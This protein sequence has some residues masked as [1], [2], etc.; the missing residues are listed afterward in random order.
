MRRLLIIGVTLVMALNGVAAP[1][2]K[3]ENNEKPVKHYID[4]FGGAGVSSFGYS[5]E[6]GKNMIGVSF[7]VGAGYTWF[8]KPYMGLQTGLSL[9]RIASTASLT[10]PM[11]WDKWQDGSP[12]TDYMGEKYIHRTTFDGW[13]E[14]QQA[15]LIQ[16]PI[17]LRFRYF[18][19][20]DQKAG[21]HA[22]VGVNLSIPVISSYAHTAGNVT[23]VGWYEQ[24]Q[25]ELHD[26]PGRF[27][28][29]PFTT[30]QEESLA[31][32]VNIANVE[33]YA[34]L[35]TL[36]RLDQRSELFIAA[37]AQYML[38]DF[39]AVKRADRTPLGFANSHNNYAFMPEYN[40]LIGTDKIGA[41]HPWVAGLKI[42]V[43][44]S[45]IKT[46]KEKKKKLKELAKEFPDALPV[47]EIHD[48]IYIHD[49]L[50]IE[51]ERKEIIVVQRTAEEEQRAVEQL[52]SMLSEAVIWF[53][54]D[55]YVPILEPVGILDSIADM[56]HRYPHLRIHVNGHACRIGTDA[57]NQRLA[58]KRAQAVAD[59]L[60]KKGINE[61][62][63]F[64]WSYSSSHPYRYNK[65][66]QL[67]KDRRVEIIPDLNNVNKKQL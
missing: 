64:I 1:S 47:K 59:L 67:S 38:N 43:S 32:R 66:H 58:L 54:F 55:E 21:L 37:Y 53:H 12:L 42:G 52:D 60:V 17:G 31:S 56:L 14:Q 62:R 29:E 18:A 10:E 6:G 45:P 5:L 7:S 50:C 2:K 20:K 30:K 4:I 57:Y 19:N 49:T 35:G 9:T 48:T 28:T 3:K 51:N 40:G 8:F 27:E 23:H 22:A 33:A 46:D 16:V 24:W 44:V 36:I 63:M 15:Y 13:K 34:E 39:S 41:M 11:L 26:L 25:L 61:D 65:D